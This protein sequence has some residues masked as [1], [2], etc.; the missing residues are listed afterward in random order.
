MCIRDRKI[1]FKFDEW[2]DAEKLMAGKR[3]LE[4]LLEGPAFALMAIGDIQYVGL[5]QE[6]TDNLHEL[7][8]EIT[9]QRL[10]GVPQQG[11]VVYWE[12]SVLHLDELPYSLVRTYQKPVRS[13]V[14]RAIKSGSM[15]PVLEALNHAQSVLYRINEPVL[16]LVRECYDK[17]IPVEGLPSKTKL[18]EPVKSEAWED[19][20]D[21]EKYLWKRKAK[22]I[23]IVNI[24]LEGQR[25]VLERDLAMADHLLGKPYWIPMNVDYRSRFYGISHFN[26]QRQD[27]IRALFMFDEGQVVTP[28]GLLWLKVHLAN[29]GDFNKVSKKTFDERIW[30]VDDNIDA[31][32]ATAKEPLGNLWWTKADKP[33]LFVAACMALNDA[34]NGKEVHLPCSWDGSCSGLQHLAAMSLGEDEA[35]LVNLTITNQGPQDIYQTVAD[36]V[37]VKIENDL[38]SFATLQFKNKSNEEVRTVAVSDLAKMCLDY[39]VNRKLV[40]RNTMTFSYSSKRAG[41]MDQLLED[42]MRPLALEVLA[43]NISS[44]PFGDDGGYAA[45]RYL[46]GITYSS[47]VDTVSKPAEVMRYLQSIARVMAHESK[48]VTWTTPLG[49]PVMLRTP[50]TTS[51]QI[52]LFLHDKGVKTRFK[53]R[54][55]VETTGINKQKAANAVAPSVVH[56]FDACHLQMVVLAAKKE[57]INS[58]AL[59][60][61]SFGC[62]PNEAPKFRELIKQTFVELYE[63]N[64]VLQNIWQ[65][66]FAHLDTHGYRMPEIPTKGTLDLQSILKADY[67]FA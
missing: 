27:H 42:T 51:T 67:A 32:I 59:V 19:M 7:V 2:T 38:T 17:G 40:K 58:I 10:M 31:I 63:R 54:S 46:S 48:P 24:S 66:N 30:W 14:D 44:H 62:L 25:V 4:V 37:K 9:L 64:D 11:N 33:F 23:A 52:E 13:H 47:I 18:P 65:E 49:F 41:M 50:N 26:F 29:C 3:M 43:G 45:A 22:E 55:L 61:D 34:M 12:S 36:L 6:A 57:G 1:D 21:D 20:T 5:T 28:E 8:A 15:S 53:P 60:H 16:A 39:G 35:K 56:S